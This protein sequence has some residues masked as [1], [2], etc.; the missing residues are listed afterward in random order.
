MLEAVRMAVVNA[1]HLPKTPDRR[2]YS[3]APDR[4]S[5]GR[6]EAVGTMTVSGLHGWP[7]AHAV[8][9]PFD[10][11]H[12]DLS[13]GRIGPAESADVP[14]NPT[15]RDIGASRAPA[16]RWNAGHEERI[17]PRIPEHDPVPLD[18]RRCRLRRR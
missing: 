17:G 3:G 5:Y 15:H 8:V 1:S 10:S 6:T 7:T 16:Q 14:R 12:R 2:D 9:G 13:R 4:S 11:G 18:R